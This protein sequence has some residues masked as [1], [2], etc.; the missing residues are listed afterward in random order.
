[1]NATR[2]TRPRGLIAAIMLRFGPRITIRVSPEAFFLTNGD[3]ALSLAT[4]LYLDSTAAGP[5]VVAVGEEVHSAPDLVRVDLFGSSMHASLPP[6]VSMVECLAA[7]LR[8]GVQKVVGRRTMIVPRVTVT[9]LASFDSTLRGYRR[10]FYGRRSKQLGPPKL[11]FPRL[12]VRSNRALERA[13]QRPAQYEWA[14]CAVGRS[15]P[16]R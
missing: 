12:S 11:I 10:R 15:T 6:R 9:G 5:R 13:G 14:L 16:G 3:T 2:A 1:M 8:Y 4:Y 7:F